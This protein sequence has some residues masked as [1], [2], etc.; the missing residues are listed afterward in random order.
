MYN[1]ISINIYS[2]LGEPLNMFKI[3]VDSW[4]SQVD[5]AFSDMIP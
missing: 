4:K 1:I 3:S 2:G 5:K